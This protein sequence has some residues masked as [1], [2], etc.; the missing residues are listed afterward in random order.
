[1]FVGITAMALLARVHVSS[2]PA[3]LV[4]APAGYSQRTVIAQLASAVFGDGSVGFY[5]VQAFTAAIL[6]LAANTAFNGFPIL[7]SILGRIMSRVLIVEDDLPLLRALSINLRARRYD[8]DTAANG[9][10][11]RVGFGRDADVGRRLGR[12]GPPAGMATPF[13]WL[14]PTCAVS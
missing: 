11:A 8:V 10:T 5:A 4:G 6:V 13:H 12:G 9:V 14:N 1:M 3:A 7:A 2:D